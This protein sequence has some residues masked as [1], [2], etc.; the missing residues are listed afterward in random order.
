LLG[1]FIVAILVSLIFMFLLRC[2]AGCIVW[3]SIFGTIGSLTVLGFIFC[4]SGGLF[5]PQN[6]SYMGY[7]VPTIAAD[8]QYLN[9][10][11]YGVWGLAGLLLIVILCLC[12]RIR[13][14]VAVC[15][16]AGKFIV[17]TCSV[18]FV[19]IIMALVTVGLW[20]V[21]SVVMIY[22]VSAA[23]FV[24]NGDIFTSLV[25]YTQPNLA[26][27][28]YF[29]FGTLWSNALVQAMTTF[30][31]ASS[32]CMWYFSH[33]PG[34]SLHLPVLRSYGRAFRYH[35]GSLAFGSLLVAIVQ[36]LQLMVEAFKKQAENTGADKN[37]AMEYLIN[38]LRCCL[39]CV[40]RIVQFINKNAY[41][42]IALSGKNFC[43]AAKD[44]FELVWSNPLRY[45]IVGGVGSIIMFLGKILIAFG[46]AMA[47]YLYL[48]YAPNTVMGKLLFLFV[49][50][51]LIL[52][53][54]RLCLCCFSSFYDRLFVGNGHSA[55]L[56]HRR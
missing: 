21:C 29:V 15:K 39:A 28:Y 16:C 25:D 47:M 24:A 38:C 22:L 12:N 13:L 6:V 52:A 27:F 7:T 11:G 37:K 48:T 45:A 5:G 4:Y 36:F 51:I 40:E 20:A 49:N 17:E 35:F 14:A 54:L 46:T 1:A 53:C 33:G 19:P 3:V 56:L 26:R 18:M 8:Q 43:M 50:F 34:E 31:V 55:C 2:L 10:Y 42:Q 32:C 30:I 23:N 44:G 9:Y 41:I